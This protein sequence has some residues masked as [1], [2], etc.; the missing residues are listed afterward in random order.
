MTTAPMSRAFPT[1]LALGA[2][3]A[4]LAAQAPDFARDV[5]P[6]LARHCYPCHGPDGKERKADLRLDSFAAA[7]A[8]RK[9][10]ARP[11]APGDA[12]H[13]EL[14]RR[15]D[16]GDASV[17][18]P[19]PAAN[20][21]LD[22]RERAVLRAWIA[23]GADYAPHWAF[24]PP[25]KQSPAPL[26]DESWCRDELDRFVLAR[27]RRE[28]LAPS[29]PADPATLLRRAHLALTGLPPTPAEVAAFAADPSRRA[30]ERHVDE[31]LA[32][33]ACAEHLAAPWL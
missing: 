30:Y 4:T 14:L 32:R 17:M 1:A 26:G 13:S 22:D 23:A 27:L 33:P 21:P 24:V 15:I 6:V 12:A 28:G 20:K 25:Q 3:A 8:V 16:S 11:I 2:A 31:L 19:P 7:T 29:P 10:G 9:R 5:Q 18:M